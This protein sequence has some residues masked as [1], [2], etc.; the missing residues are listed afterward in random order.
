M[1][2]CVSGAGGAP[3]PP[4]GV[5]YENFYNKEQSFWQPY[6]ELLPAE[7]PGHLCWMQKPE[8]D[9]LHLMHKASEL[10]P[11]GT[12]RAYAF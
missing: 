2:V 3:P 8:L 10:Y 1:L 11:H 5:L 6:L 9:I 4:Q 7:F 12:V